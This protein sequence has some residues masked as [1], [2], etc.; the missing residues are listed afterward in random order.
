MASPAAGRAAWTTPPPTPSSSA[1]VVELGQWLAVGPDRDLHLLARPHGLRHGPVV[2]VVLGLVDG[3]GLSAGRVRG[4]VPAAVG[5]GD[6]DRVGAAHGVAGQQH[7][8]LQQVVERLVVEHGCRRVRTRSVSCPGRSL[9]P[10]VAFRRVAMR[11]ERRVDSSGPTPG[12]A[13]ASWTGGSRCAAD[14]S[15]A[16]HRSNPTAGLPTGPAR[17]PRLRDG[18]S[19]PGQHVLR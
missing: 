8:L 16:G 7:H 3:Q 2:A 19:S 12:F 13:A 5:D 15:P 17:P 18:L 1:L 14:P 9:R 11:T 4:A 10:Q 6:A